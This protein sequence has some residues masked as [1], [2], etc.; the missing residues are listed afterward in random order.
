[1]S[2]TVINRGVWKRD[3]SGNK[4][5]LVPSS[6]DGDAGTVRVVVEGIEHVFAPGQ[7]KTFGDDGIGI[8]VS[9]ADG[10]LALADTREGFETKTKRT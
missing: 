9:A 2:V 4:T 6:L 1:M 8:A 5:T 7:S 10:R 3:T